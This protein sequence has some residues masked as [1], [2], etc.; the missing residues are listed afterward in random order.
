MRPSFTLTPSQCA[1]FG[2]RGIVLLPQFFARNDIASMR[3]ALWADLKRRH[4]ILRDKPETWSVVR[5]AQFQ[6]LVRSG[7]FDKLG[8]PALIDLTDALL[9]AESWTAPRHWGLPLVTMPSR[10]PD[11]PRAMWHFDIPGGD[12]RAQLPALRVFTFLEPVAA[13]GGGTL[14]VAGSHRLAIEIAVREGALPS[15]KM[16]A[17]LAATHPWFAELFA[18]SGDGEIRARMN[19][20]ATISGIEV[21][22]DQ[23]MGEPG[24]AILMHPLML[25]GVAHNASET[26]RAMVTITVARKGTFET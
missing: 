19:E 17:R 18:R 1:A 25:H 24:D 12:Y 20:R 14:V 9:G 21:E 6:K 23:L 22:I 26:P 8:T 10:H 13:N 4:G 15:A 11:L 7:V 2:E 3:N 16:R 5:P